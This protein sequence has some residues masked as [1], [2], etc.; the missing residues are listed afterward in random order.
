VTEWTFFFYPFIAH[1]FDTFSFSAAS[2]L[3]AI[4]FA[5]DFGF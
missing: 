5:D 4:P 1:D 3:T 2:T